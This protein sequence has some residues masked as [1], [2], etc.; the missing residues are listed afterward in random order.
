MCTYSC[1]QSSKLTRHMK[2]HRR[3]V[4]DIF[5]VSQIDISEEGLIQSGML[6]QCPFCEMPFGVA[7]ILEKHTRW[8]VLRRQ[9]TQSSST[10]WGSDRPTMRNIAPT[11]YAK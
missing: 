2:T 6:F 5:K 11:S 3:M 9:E 4:K 1:A 7:S 8:C 10:L